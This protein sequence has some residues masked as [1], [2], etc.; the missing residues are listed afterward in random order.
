MISVYLLLD[1]I[2]SLIINLNIFDILFSSY[3][4]NVLAK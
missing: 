3:V 2:S 1:C 4:C